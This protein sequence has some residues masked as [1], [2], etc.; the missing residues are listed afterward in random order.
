[1]S[2]KKIKDD[3]LNISATTNERIGEQ[4][5]EAQETVAPVRGTTAV[6]AI[7][8]PANRKRLLAYGGAGVLV[9]AALTWVF[10]S[11]EE[12]EV[13]QGGQ[14]RVRGASLQART[15][16]NPSAIQRAE[17]DRYNADVLPEKQEKDPSAHPVI[18]TENA[19]AN[20]FEPKKQF[21]RATK[22]SEVGTS[23]RQQTQPQAQ[24][25]RGNRKS[26]ENKGMDDLLKSLI[27]AEGA[28]VP[29]SY[30]VE[31]A[32][33]QPKSGGNAK[34]ADAKNGEPGK[35][36]N[37]KCANPATRAA[38]MYMATA[39]I[40]LNSDVGGPVSLTI[41]NGRLRGTQLL[42]EFERK[43]EWLRMTLKTIVT[44]E[45]TLPVEAIGLDMDTTLNAVQGD[46]D[47]HILYRYGWWGFGTVL[48]AIGKAAEANADSDVVIT[49]GAVV[50]STSSDAQREMKMALGSMGDSIGAAFQNRINRPITVSLKVND[51]V[52]VFFL[53]DVCLPAEESDY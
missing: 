39:D 10:F 45:H 42:G 1:M 44:D 7:F 4:A 50:E 30:S 8:A 31:W 48:S 15:N 21:K 46:V 32:Y 34:A 16:E 11:L 6:K 43:E 2:D 3:D 51:E 18:V 9:L 14:S 38:T 17:A 5:Y 29:S 52:G 26:D 35:D 12:Q 25:Q 49:N 24:A 28:K 47:R 41:R 36:S 40:A 37:K 20:P 33:A 13:V 27:D 22:L 23:E 53:K 19:D